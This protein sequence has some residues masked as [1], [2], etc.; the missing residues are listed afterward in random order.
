MRALVLIAALMASAPAWAQ[1]ETQT[2]AP[3]Q[4]SAPAQ[5]QPTAGTPY[6][7]P[8][9]ALERTFIAAMD[10]PD[11]RAVFRVQFLESQVA[12]AL[13]SREPSAPPRMINLPTGARACL[14][15]TSPA[16][17]NAIMG[18]EAA[19]RV[20]T[21]RE[22]LELVRGANVIININLRPYLTLDS[23]GINSFLAIPETPAAAPEVEAED[24]AATED[25]SAGPTQ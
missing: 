3:A 24:P 14:I 13:S 20:M 17:A 6:I 21:G 8:E 12:L 19:Y 4:T 18:D 10:N 11:M 25:P 2:P 1:T 23:D 5:A 22:A 9:N 7:E 16:R 15:F